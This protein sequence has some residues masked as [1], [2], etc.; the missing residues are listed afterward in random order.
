MDSK[1][2]IWK[3]TVENIVYEKIGYTLDDLPDELYR[4]NFDNG[5]TAEYMAEKVIK[6]FNDGFV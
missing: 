4:D 3:T 5:S 6:N 1:F 2:Y